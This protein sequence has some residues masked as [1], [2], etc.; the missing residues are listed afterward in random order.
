MSGR[1]LGVVAF[2]MLVSPAARSPLW[3]VT[4]RCDHPTHVGQVLTLVLVAQGSSVRR[5]RS[6][7]RVF[8]SKAIA[9]RCPRRP[10]T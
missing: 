4:T 2:V 6:A 3:Y 7:S 8:R 1:T 9:Q 10:V 5:V